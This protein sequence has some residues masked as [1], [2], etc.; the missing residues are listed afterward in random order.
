MTDY[1]YSPEKLKQMLSIAG[2]IGSAW[3]R[4]IEFREIIS[5]YNAMNLAEYSNARK[6][7]EVALHYV[8]LRVKPEFQDRA[9]CLTCKIRNEIERL[10]AV[11]D[12]GDIR[13][14]SLDNPAKI[15][16]NNI[17]ANHLL[18]AQGD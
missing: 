15:T 7:F 3:A 5:G 18:S 17:M 16:M 2:Q 10:I 11:M 4:D 14:I 8:S 6:H 13:K 1:D 9:D 12:D